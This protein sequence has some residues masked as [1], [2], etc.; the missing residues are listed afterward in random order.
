MSFG[1]D[2]Q[3]YTFG[4]TNKNTFWLPEIFDGFFMKL[5]LCPQIVVN[6]KNYRS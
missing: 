3:S 6:L 1:F 4:M 5:Y 2:K